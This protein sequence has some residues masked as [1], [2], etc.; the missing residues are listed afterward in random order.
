MILSAF[1]TV[2]IQ[3]ARKPCSIRP[4][5]ML[6]SSGTHAQFRRFGCAIS[7]AYADTFAPTS[8]QCFRND[9]RQM[10]FPSRFRKIPF[11]CYLGKNPFLP[12]IILLFPDLLFLAPLPYAFPACP[13]LCDSLSPFPQQCLVFHCLYSHAPPSVSVFP[14]VSFGFAPIRSDSLRHIFS[15]YWETLQVRF[16]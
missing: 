15:L 1:F 5:S 6:N 13:A 16:I 4:E 14:G 12:I 2:N 9:P 8:P 7:T 10:S 3:L 11:S